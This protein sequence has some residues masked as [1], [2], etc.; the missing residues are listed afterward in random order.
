MICLIA[1]IVFGILGIFSVKYRK[2]AAE[3]FDCVARRVT[4]RKCTSRLDQRLKST[5]VGKLMKRSRGSAKFVHKY[6][7]VFSWFFLILLIVSLGFSAYSIYNYARF[8]NCNG[9]ESNEFCIFDSIRGPQFS[10]QEGDVCGAPEHQDKT[11]ELKV[12]DVSDEFF[13]GPADAPITLIEFGCYSCH[14]SKKAE[15]VV[16]EILDKYGDKIK[17]VFLHYPIL[18]HENSMDAAI[19]SECA[20][21]QG[22]FW[23]YHVGLFEKSPDIGFDDL[24]S[25]CEVVGLEHMAFNDCLEENAT[26]SVIERHIQMGADAGVYGTPTFFINDV[27]LVGP[28]SFERMEKVI[29]EELD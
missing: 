2:I 5:I 19:A 10:E 29:L 22:N 18:T 4:F 17:F 25:C 21:Q 16:E 13:I 24:E 15:P 1:L 12:P 14:Y 3:A 26:R 6:F 7:E 23:E 20:R 11:Q 8:G 9:P 28:K 27:P